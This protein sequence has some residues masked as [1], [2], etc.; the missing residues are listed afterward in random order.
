MPRLH[1]LLVVPTTTHAPAAADH[2]LVQVGPGTEDETPMLGVQARVGMA[3]SGCCGAAKAAAPVAGTATV[4]TD[5]AIATTQARGANAAGTTAIATP[6]TPATRASASATAA[7]PATS[8]A[9][10]GSLLVRRAAAGLEGSAL[11]QQVLR[12]IEA[13]GARIE[14]L[15][16]GQF[17]QEFGERTQGAFDPKTNVISLPQ[18]VA[19]SPEK[20]RLVMLHEG[21]HWLQDNVAGGA[22]ALGGPIGDALRSACAVRTTAPGKADVQHDEAQAYLLEALVANELGIRDT[23]MGVDSNGRALTYDA[24]MQKIRRTAEYA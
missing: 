4:T 17:A 1:A 14:T 20:L 23:G 15:P 6:A 7:S 5:T 13:S 3:T 18:S 16:D 22:E 10:T 2:G 21:I 12:T 24:I 11:A 8:A 19:S 9:G